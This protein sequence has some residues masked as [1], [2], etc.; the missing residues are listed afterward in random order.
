MRPAKPIEIQQHFLRI[1][2]LRR[3]KLGNSVIGN[4]LHQMHDESRRDHL[5]AFLGFSLG[6]FRLDSDELLVGA[7][8]VASGELNIVL[9]G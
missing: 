9:D 1:L 3:G 7:R 2:D 4:L 8:E 6:R 5:S